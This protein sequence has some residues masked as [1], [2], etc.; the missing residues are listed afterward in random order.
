MAGG[1]TAGD[2][3]T[4]IAPVTTG[5]YQNVAVSGSVTGDA[6]GILFRNTSGSVDYKVGLRPDGNTDD[7]GADLE[8]SG[9]VELWCVVGLSDQVEI[10]VENAAIECYHIGTLDSSVIEAIEDDST[11]ATNVSATGTGWQ[12][13]TSSGADRAAAGIRMLSINANR[14]FGLRHPDQTVDA[15][16]DGG[17]VNGGIVPMKNN[18]DLQYYQHVNTTDQD[19]LV[20]FYIKAEGFTYTDRQDDLGSTGAYA[21]LTAIPN[22][23]YAAT[24]MVYGTDT[25]QA[26]AMRTKS[27]S[28]DYYNRLQNRAKTFTRHGDGSGIV[29]AKISATGVDMRLLGTFTEFTASSSALPYRYYADL[30]EN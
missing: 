15:R 6:V 9:N 23:D 18:Q 12:T 25:T 27:A 29:E 1:Y 17:A 20:Q 13:Y 24:W 3:T 5:S 4:D 14:D 22:S 26:A 2:F 21:D 30:Y 8:L 19:Y 16:A 7:N 11:S 10:F 28:D